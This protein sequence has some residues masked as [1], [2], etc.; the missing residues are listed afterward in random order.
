MRNPLSREDDPR[1]AYQV[2]RLEETHSHSFC[3]L[4]LCFPRMGNI[5]S[6]DGVTDHDMNV[7]KEIT[8]ET[9][10]PYDDPIWME[11]FEMQGYL[12]AISRAYL[13]AAT[14]AWTHDMRGALICR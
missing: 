10:Y 8:L 9:P 3:Q 5:L 11:V 7:V 1:I 4:I 6:D 12:Q 13:N 14:T 2:S